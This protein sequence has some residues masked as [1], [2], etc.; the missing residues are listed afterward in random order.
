[1]AETISIIWEMKFIFMQNVQCINERKVD[2]DMLNAVKGVLADVSSVSP[3]SEQFSC[4][5]V[6][7]MQLAN[8]L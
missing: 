6:S 4:N 7:A 3:S 2:V 1:M 5:T 8:P